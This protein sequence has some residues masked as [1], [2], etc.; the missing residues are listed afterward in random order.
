[1][2]SMNDLKTVREILEKFY[3]LK[4]NPTFY[5]GSRASSTHRKNSDLDIFIDDKTIK[6]SDMSYMQEAFEQSSLPFKI[7][8]VL[9]SRIDDSF[10][11][12]IRHEL[13]PL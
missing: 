7:D 4:L 8:I 12:S 2:N 10:Y 9:K 6:P 3:D 5:F 1:M 11:N 13:R